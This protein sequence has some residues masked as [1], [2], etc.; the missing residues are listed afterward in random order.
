MK[1]KIVCVS[2]RQTMPFNY[3][4]YLDNMKD[5]TRKLS[6]AFRSTL[7]GKCYYSIP[8]LEDARAIKTKWNFLNYEINTGKLKINDTIYI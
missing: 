5:N 7:T 2:G 4:E 3:T 6:Y 8:S 1:Y